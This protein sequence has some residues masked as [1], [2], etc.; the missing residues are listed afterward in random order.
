MV[1]LREE[2]QKDY[3]GTFFTRHGYVCRVADAV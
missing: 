3:F 2:H 1:L